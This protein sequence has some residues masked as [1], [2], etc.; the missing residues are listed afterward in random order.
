[1]AGN[2]MV[3]DGILV[4][5]SWCHRATVAQT[6]DVLTGCDLTRFDR[7]HLPT[8]FKHLDTVFLVAFLFGFLWGLLFGYWLRL[9]WL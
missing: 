5:Q 9:G 6:K 8:V 3:K 7:L 4:V 1:M 2:R